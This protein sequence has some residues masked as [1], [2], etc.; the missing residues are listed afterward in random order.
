MR[1]AAER[2]FVLKRIFARAADSRR[3]LWTRRPIG[4]GDD[5][6]FST[7]RGHETILTCDWFLEGTHFCATS[8]RPTRGGILPGLSDVRRWA[9]ST[10]FSAESGVARVAYRA[11]ARCLPGRTAAGLRNL[12]APCRRRHTRRREILLV[13]RVAKS[14]H[15]RCLLL[16][17]S[18][19]RH[20]LLTD[21]WARRN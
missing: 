4:Y 7:K 12:L 1:H 9:E 15:T 21:G 19:G 2:E 10:V 11:L 3:I 16:R 13:S 14:M 5:R 18:R 17:S 20:Y 8:I 6:A